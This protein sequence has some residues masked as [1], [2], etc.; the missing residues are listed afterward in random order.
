MQGT[1]IPAS[2]GCVVLSDVP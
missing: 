1:L 2:P